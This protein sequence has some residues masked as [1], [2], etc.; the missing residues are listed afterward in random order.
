MPEFPVNAQYEITDGTAAPPTGPVNF[1]VFHRSG[2]EIGATFETYQRGKAGRAAAES[3]RLRHTVYAISPGVVE[4]ERSTTPGPATTALFPV[5]DTRYNERFFRRT[6]ASGMTDAV[7]CNVT[8]VQ[9]DTPETDVQLINVTLMA[10]GSV[11]RT[12][13]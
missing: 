2:F 1:T 6:F 8:G 11:T 3:G 13:F 10:T 7:N 9:P 4:A 5:N 12:G